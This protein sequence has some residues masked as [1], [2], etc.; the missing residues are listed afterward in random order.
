MKKDCYFE[1]ISHKS[2]VTISSPLLRRTNC[3]KYI[4]NLNLAQFI[5]ACYFSE[6]YLDE[7]KLPEPVNDYESFLK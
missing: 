4:T 1:K 7:Y 6:K 5:D 3:A 2:P